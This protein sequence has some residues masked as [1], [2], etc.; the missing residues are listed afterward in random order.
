MPGP[1]GLLALAALTAPVQLAYVGL[2]PGQEFIPYF[3]ALLGLVGTALVAALQRPVL[4]LLRF[5]HTAGRRLRHGPNTRPVAAGAA[6][7]QGGSRATGEPNDGRPTRADGPEP[8]PEW[9]RRG[10][11][12]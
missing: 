7:R 12:P 6:A 2:G 11:D 4:A 10:E 8:R 1:N 5:L 3:F 9:V